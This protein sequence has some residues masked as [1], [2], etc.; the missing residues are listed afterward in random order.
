MSRTYFDPAAIK[1]PALLEEQRLSE[2][3]CGDLVA[4][5]TC[6]NQDEGN[7]PQGYISKDKNGQWPLNVVT[8]PESPKLGCCDGMRSELCSDKA[9]RIMESGKGSKTSCRS[10][11]SKDA[12]RVEKLPAIKTSEVS[13]SSCCSKTNPPDHN[14]AARAGTIPT[15]CLGSKA[16]KRVQDSSDIMQPIRPNLASESGCCKVP[17]AEIPTGDS[18]LGMN[19][20]DLEKAEVDFEHFVLNIK[21]MDCTGCE[22]KLSRAISSLQLVH[23]LT[24]SLLMAQ[25]QFD[26]DVS[27]SPLTIDEVIISI[28]KMTGYTCTRISKLGQQLDVTLRGSVEDFMAQKLPP[29]I[30]NMSTINKST[31]RITYDAAVIGARDLLSGS[32]LSSAILAPPAISPG[33]AADRAHFRK[34]LLRTIFSACLTIPV[35]VLAWAPLPRHP[36]IYGSTSLALA[37]IIQV[38]VAG[39]F[40]PAAFKTLIYARMIEMDLLIVLS[41]STAY[42]YSVIAFV[43]E[44]RGSPLSTGGF[45]ETSV[46]LV[47]L[48]MAGRAV[49]AFARQKAVETISLESLRA[50][51]ALLYHSESNAGEEIDARLLQY[52]DRFKIL[53]DMKI[54]TDGIVESGETEVDESMITGEATP[55]IKTKGSDVIA[56]SVNSFGTVVVKLV[57]LPGESS[58]TVIGDMLDK[59]KFMKPKIQE[60]ANRVASYFIPTIL[61]M[62]VV[63]LVVWIAVGKAVRHQSTATAAITAM[64]YAIS[65][66]IISCPCAIG[67]AV[68][69]VIV[70][71]GGVAAKHGI[72]LKSASAIETARK[73]THVIF[74]KTGTLTQGTLSVVSEIHLAQQDDLS[75]SLALGLMSNSKHPVSSS[76]AAYLKGKGVT[77]ATI[78]DIVSLVGKGVEGTWNGSTVHAG[79]ARWL[80]LEKLPSV[81][82]LFSSGLTVLC[83]SLGGEPLAIFGLEDSLRPDAMEVVAKLQDRHVSVSIISGDNTAAV[84]SLAHKLRIPNTHVRAECSPTDKQAYIQSFSSPQTTILFC[85][86]GTNDALALAQADIGM[87]M[88]EGTDIASH[89]ADAVLLRPAL[90]GILILMDLSAAFHR[91]V[92][93][94]FC[95]A[96]VYNL[97][98][99]ALAAGAFVHVRIQ[100]QYAG[101]GELVSVLPVVGI[102][103]QLRWVKF[104]EA[105]DS[106]RRELK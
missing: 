62:T 55:V 1:N 78:Q 43:Y 28:Q 12:C 71:A 14:Q 90:S 96:F 19:D 67:L 44:V 65:A 5:D 86:D 15:I 98:A 58:I 6:S 99:V 94:N 2:G 29:G 105:T 93:F 42:V 18:L 25:A 33:I 3:Y 51:T 79:N 31:I 36:I 63:V 95:W 52:G 32:F 89:A 91:R 49:S 30:L 45:F 61:L 11:D 80:D 88:S 68:P 27:T 102:A 104:G 77:P 66:L 64:T 106:K 74:D 59:A 4:T 76:V 70:V 54:V 17:S 103:M 46:L 73:V 35:L 101:L 41:T 82:N 84:S 48:I 37:T 21:G 50:P 23:N 34:M 40:Y 53:P 22:K 87:H 20:R 75:R 24:T 72:I 16:L 13:E 38:V 97:F 10:P 92:C 9:L 7:D 100:P 56:G 85:G 26:L 60:T 69:M 39:P 81:Q 83:L 57:R 47:T 8:A